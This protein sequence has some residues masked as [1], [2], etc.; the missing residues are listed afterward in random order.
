MT[1]VFP[2]PWSQSA[3]TLM[4]GGTTSIHGHI[5]TRRTA[6]EARGT[7]TG[8]MTRGSTAGTTHGA[9]HGTTEATGA[10]GTTLGT[11]GDSGDGMT[12]GTIQDTGDIRGIRIMRDGMAVSV[13]YG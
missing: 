2:A 3:R 10:D 8:G 9:T 13:L 12:H 1:R 5:I 11:T 7:G 4:T 6:S